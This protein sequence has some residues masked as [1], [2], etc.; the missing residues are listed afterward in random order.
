MHLFT[1]VDMSNG[2]VAR[3]SLSTSLRLIDL[4]ILGVSNYA[5]TFF[6]HVVMHCHVCKNVAT[7]AHN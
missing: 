4:C 3:L 1:G 6:I 2:E 5:L 7:D